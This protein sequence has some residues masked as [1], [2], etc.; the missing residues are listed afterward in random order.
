M[1]PKIVSKVETPSIAWA[2][3]GVAIAATAAAVPTS[4]PFNR[5]PGAAGAKKT[6]ARNASM[7]STS[8]TALEN[9]L[10]LVL[11]MAILVAM[12]AS[13]RDFARSWRAVKAAT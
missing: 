5:R 10:L 12:R 13:A 11:G 1:T 3:S 9:R 2:G 6:K 4:A 7:E 8:A